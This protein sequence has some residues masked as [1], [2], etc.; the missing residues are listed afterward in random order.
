MKV[1][2]QRGHHVFVLS[3]FP[4][5]E[6]LANY[7]DISL[8]GSI[9]FLSPTEGISLQQMAGQSIMVIHKALALMGVTTC[10]QVLN[11]P[12]V[13]QLLQSNETYDL[14]IAELFNTD[15]FLAFAHR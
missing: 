2:A 6:P 14:I 12:A 1:L 11:Y 7:T 10:E 4:Q 9:N 13:Q 5:V 3:H 15:C 8:K